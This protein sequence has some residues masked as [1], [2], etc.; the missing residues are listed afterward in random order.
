MIDYP[1]EI[2]R[3]T[4]VQDHADT[5][6]DSLDDL[7]ETMTTVT[8]RWDE[9]P[10]V[11]QTPESQSVYDAMFV[12]ENLVADLAL[13]L[14]TAHTALTT[15]ADVL[16]DLNHRR[17]G[18]VADVDRWHEMSPSDPGFADF[19]Y[20]LDQRLWTFDLDL[21]IADEDCERVLDG[22]RLFVH[23][24]LTDVVTGL[25][26]SAQGVSR[27]A[28]AEY[29]GVVQQRAA[30]TMSTTTVTTVIDITVVRIQ[31]IVPDV[32]R[33]GVAYSETPNGFYVPTARL[34][35]LQLSPPRMVVV[36]SVTITSTNLHGAL[37]VVPRWAR[38]GGRALPVLGAGVSF[39][40][41]LYEHYNE[42]LVTEPYMSDAD[43]WNEAINYA[44]FVTGAETAG[45]LV[46]PVV[47]GA[48]F[49]VGGLPTGPGAALTG[50]LG[51]LAGGYLGGTGAGWLAE[52]IWDWTH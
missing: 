24:P 32:I 8:G 1:R 40:G 28:L 44:L 12:P 27:D 30:T 23:L 45:G 50:A 13:V 6:H 38:V 9:L 41:H 5:L 3:G 37:P 4:A 26:S 46:G 16:T 52:Q 2:P 20:D 47:V 49:A 7:V 35:G 43:R 48:L 22:L 39:T 14:D 36:G 15:F 31:D 51:A 17:P 29:L 42:L 19:E 11:Y 10:A 34:T 21:D 33:D 18:L 25:S